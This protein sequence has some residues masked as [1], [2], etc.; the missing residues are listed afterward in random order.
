MQG[1]L[2][3]DEKKVMFTEMKE[4]SQVFVKDLKKGVE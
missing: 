3:V 2:N 4:Q 1:I